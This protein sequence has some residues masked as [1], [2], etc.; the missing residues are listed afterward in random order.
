M[1]MVISVCLYIFTNKH[2]SEIV[3]E[4]KDVSITVRD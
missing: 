3:V 4:N 2:I 1:Q